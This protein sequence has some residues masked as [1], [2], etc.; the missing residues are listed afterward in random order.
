MLQAQNRQVGWQSV[1]RKV[2]I[3]S[4]ATILL[5]YSRVTTASQTG[6]LEHEQQ[7]LLKKLK[8]LLL[9]NP[10]LEWI[11]TTHAMRLYIHNTSKK[12]GL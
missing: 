7:P 1:V 10:V 8:I 6:K 2:T 4:Y 9:F 3:S 12:S 11:D 5:P